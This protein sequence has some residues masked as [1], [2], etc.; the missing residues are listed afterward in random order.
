MD[1][2]AFVENIKRYCAMRKVKPTVA[3][4][5]SGAGVNFI[6]KITTQG[7]IPSVERVQ[8]LAQYLGVTTSELLGESLPNV[9][10]F[11]EHPDL[12]ILYDQLSEGARQEVMA[13]VEFKR[14]QETKAAKGST[15]L[16]SLGDTRPAGMR[17]M[18]RLKEKPEDL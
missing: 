15:P 4:R 1:K 13:F 18:E 16:E 7:S 9:P 8:L 17:E 12:V 5:E 6:N 3:C 10:A 14:T 2:D 11:P